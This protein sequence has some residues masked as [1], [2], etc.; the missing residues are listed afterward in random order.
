M[1]FTGFPREGL[2][3]LTD[4]KANNTKEWFDD[5][6]ATYDEKVLAPA[7]A[8]VLEMGARLREIAPDIRAEPKINK[9]LFRIYRD[10]RFSQDKTPYKT[11]LAVWFWEGE[12]KRM[13]CPGFYFDMSPERIFMGTGIYMFPTKELLHHY[14][15]AVDD[16]EFGEALEAVVVKLKAAGLELSSGKQLKRVPREY[17]KEHVRGDLLRHKGLTAGLELPI[18]E[19][20]HSEAILDL[21]MKHFKAMN[22]LHA[23]IRELL[24]HL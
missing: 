15:E 11:N 21:C 7:R 19:E 10:T 4:L 17:D 3:F 22:P 8:F 1:T 20:V 13:E 16:D 9:S 24:V 6:R 14:R 12:G 18:S 5:N 23:W 2:Q